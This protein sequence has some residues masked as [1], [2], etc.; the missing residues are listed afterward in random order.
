MPSAVSTE[1]RAGAVWF[2]TGNKLREQAEFHTMMRLY[3]A[4]GIATV[5]MT[6]ATGFDVGEYLNTA[7]AEFLRATVHHP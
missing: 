2:A 5:I 1:K 6:S 7:D 4:S 3:P